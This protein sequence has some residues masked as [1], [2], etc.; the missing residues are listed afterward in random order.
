MFQLER[1]QQLI[2]LIIAALILFGGGYKY[3]SWQKNNAAESKVTLEQLETMPGEEEKGEE[4]VVHVTGAVEKSGVYRLPAGARVNDVL[5]KAGVQT[6]ADLDSLNLAAPL[7]DG[8]KIIVPLKQENTGVGSPGIGP[9]GPFSSGP[10]KSMAGGVTPAPGGGSL[11]NINMADQAALESL[12]GIGPALAQRIIQYREKNGPYKVP[13]DIKNVSGIG[14]KRYE[15]L[16]D[17]I[18]VY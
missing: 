18:S 14:E 2:V 16:K 10:P 7:I 6:E 9:G 12:P 15:Q 3:A 5:E 13:E 17:L 1:R 11:I 8:Q 4:I